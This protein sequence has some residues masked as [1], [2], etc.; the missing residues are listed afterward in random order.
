MN[1]MKISLMAT[2]ALACA[3]AF[4]SGCGGDDDDDDGSD[5]DD[6]DDATDD[7]ADDADDDDADDTGASDDTV[8]DDDTGPEI[9]G[10]ENSECKNGGGKDDLYP[11]GIEFSWAAGVLTVTH[12]NGSFNCCLDT[13]D[14]TMQLSSGTIDLREQEAAANPC[15]CVCPFDVATRINGLLS[16]HYLVNIYTNGVKTIS[17]ETDAP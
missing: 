3:F 2:L 9:I 5:D 17:G 11:E 6:S 7:I 15:F 13:I 10:V 8:A 12:V 1:W 4:V 14:V 16:G